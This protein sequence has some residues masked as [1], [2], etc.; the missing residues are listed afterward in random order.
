MKITQNLPA[1]IGPLLLR[2]PFML[3]FMIIL[4][5]ARPI[6]LLIACLQFLC[7]L[8]TR[9]PNSQLLHFGAT[10]SSYVYEVAQYLT[11]QTQ[12]K[13]FPFNAWPRT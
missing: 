9:S 6:L 3:L 8:F 10:L 7:L 13:P 1:H 12:A 2:V 11:Y 4:G 5:M